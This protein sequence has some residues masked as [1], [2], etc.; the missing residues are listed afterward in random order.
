MA[1]AK[2]QAGAA[3]ETEICRLL[4]GYFSAADRRDA[5]AFVECFTD[6]AVLT[7]DVGHSVSV[8]G[9]EGIAAMF[10]RLAATFQSSCHVTGS[11]HVGLDG[12]EARSDTFA[13]AYISVSGGLASDR[14]LIRGLRYRDDLVRTE[15]GWR[16]A[17]RRHRVLWQVDAEACAPHLP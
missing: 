8:V 15:R 3:D 7:A 10:D 6:D 9:H 5:A 2:E 12:D 11:V 17:V 4:K 1:E 14:V 13:V 16:I